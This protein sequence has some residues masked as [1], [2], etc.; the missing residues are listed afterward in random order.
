MVAFATKK[1]Q[2]TS[3]AAG[4]ALIKESVARMPTFDDPY[5]RG[6]AA[7]CTRMDHPYPCAPGLDALAPG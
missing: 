3:P 4:L 5:S 2:N 6:P 1:E 7:V